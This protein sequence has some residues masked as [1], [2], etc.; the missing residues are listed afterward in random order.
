LRRDAQMMKEMAMNDPGKSRAGA[1]P[2]DLMATLRRGQND[3]AMERL[4]A[5]A[6][7]GGAAEA[8]KARRGHKGY[9][10]D[11]AQQAQIQNMITE[12]RA[13]V[14]LLLLAVVLLAG[15]LAWTFFGDLL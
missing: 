14:R 12:D 10:A 11:S 7:A 4:R 8:G 2:Q 9:A 1:R 13:N 5:M 15:L 6:R 3:Q